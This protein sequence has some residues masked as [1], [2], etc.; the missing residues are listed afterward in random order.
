MLYSYAMPPP[1]E[2]CNCTI[3]SVTRLIRP[4]PRTG[5]GAQLGLLT[6]YDRPDHQSHGG[7]GIGQGQTWDLLA[8][9]NL[10]TMSR[11][12]FSSAAVPICPNAAALTDIRKARAIALVLIGE[13]SFSW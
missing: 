11:I 9:A 7:H 8:S 4:V 2:M 5:P 3:C 12:A 1:A 10:A 13:Y 6:A